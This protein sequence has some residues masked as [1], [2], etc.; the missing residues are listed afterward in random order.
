MKFKILTAILAAA[1][2]SITD[3]TQDP[4]LLRLIISLASAIM[5]ATVITALAS[6]SFITVIAVLLSMSFFLGTI[7]DPDPSTYQ[8]L[9][10][11]IACP[12]I[13][14]IAIKHGIKHDHQA[15][16]ESKKP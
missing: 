5:L 14:A 15:L 2:F 9:L 8:V 3:P 6:E 10:A 4:I 12:I 13:S 11:F 1:I 16:V 7:I